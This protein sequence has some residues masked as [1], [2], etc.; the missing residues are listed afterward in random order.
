MKNNDPK[1]LSKYIT[2]LDENKLYGWEM[3]QYHMDMENL[4]G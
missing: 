4:S 2:Y 1:K 3:N